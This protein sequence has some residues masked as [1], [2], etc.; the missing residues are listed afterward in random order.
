MIDEKSETEASKLTILDPKKLN[1][2][3]KNIN[4]STNTST[5]NKKV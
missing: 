1:A 3:L 4:S 5:T 2:K